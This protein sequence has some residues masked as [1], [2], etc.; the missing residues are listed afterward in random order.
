MQT[1]FHLL[2]LLSD[3]AHYVACPWDLGRMPEF[4]AYWLELFRNHFPRLMDQ[5]SR[6]GNRRLVPLERLEQ[7]RDDFNAY[8]DAIAREPEKFGRLSIIEICK[9]RERSLRRFDIDDPYRHA[10]Q[11]ENDTALKLLPDLLKQLEELSPSMRS[12]TLVRGIFA[13]NIFDL[14]AV[15]T[16]SR[17]RDQGVDFHAVRGELKGRPWLIDDFDQWAVRMDGQPYR[18]ALLFVDNAGSDI[19]LGMIPFAREL[20]RRGTEV[21][22]TA[23]TSP[24]LNDVTCDELIDL[25]GQIAAWDVLLA[26]SVASGRLKIVP[27]GNW[28][29]LIDLSCVS[30]TLV[31]TIEAGKIDLLVVEGMG[32]AIESNLDAR[33]NCDVLKIAM[34]KDKG[35]ANVLGGTL[36]DLVF[37]FEQSSPAGFSLGL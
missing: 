1:D 2:P 19:V 18:G 17:F 29:P 32:R 34:I 31:E 14:G 9:A 25:L 23:N 12:E 26:D 15:D 33:F 20:L 6:D 3:P 11:R 37:K 35:V 24:S 28:L 13:G 27:S 22:I 8:L 4:R 16:E 30:R 5:A 21:I 10:K 7:A 36:Y